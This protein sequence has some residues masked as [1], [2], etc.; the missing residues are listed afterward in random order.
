MNPNIQMT[1]HLYLSSL[2]M[3]TCGDHL[4]NPAAPSSSLRTR[5]KTIC[6]RP[7][8][9]VI[10][11]QT[12]GVVQ[13]I[14]TYR[15]GDELGF[16]TAWNQSM[17]ADGI[18]EKTFIT[19]ILADVNFD[20]AGLIIA[21]EDDRIVGGLMA[22]VRRTPMS[23]IDLEPDT[24]WITT[25]FVHPDYRRRGIGHALMDAAD[26]YFRQHNRHTV[27]FASYTPGYFVP[28]I[29]RIQ[30]P[31]GAALLEASGFKK[32]YQAAAMDKNLVGFEIPKDVRDVEAARRAE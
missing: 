15:S 27:Y 5:D 25:F 28:G 12:K 10:I 22:V 13:M 1:I 8:P 29:D 23:G 16:I 14:R 9:I 17:P 26:A 21:E 2:T 18:S 19:R 6:N 4:M 30:Y 32:L 11:G 7:F 31:W 24:G 20:P 3:S